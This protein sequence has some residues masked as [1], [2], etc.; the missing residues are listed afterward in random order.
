MGLPV[1]QFC[2]T[3]YSMIQQATTTVKSEKVRVTLPARP[4]REWSPEGLEQLIVSASRAETRITALRMKAIAELSRRQGRSIT[5]KTLRQ[6]C[7]Q[8]TRRAKGEVETAQRLRYLPQTSKA[9]DNGEISYRHAEIIARSAKQAPNIDERDLVDRAR[10]Q[11]ADTFAKEARRQVL[12]ASDD[13]GSSILDKQ[14]RNRTASVRL[15][16]SDGMTILFA[17]F[18]PIT[19]AQVKQVISQRVEQLWRT[20]DRNARPTT[21]QRMADALAELLLDGTERT[22]E[23]NGVGG[24]NSTLLM[25]ADYDTVTQ[26]IKNLRLGDNTPLPIG[27]LA[28]LACETKVVP[29]FFNRTGQPMW[30]GRS[31]RTASAGQRIALVA[32]D[33]GCVGC[34]ADPS[35]CQAHHIVP[36]AEG[37]PTTLENMCL[38]CSRCHHQ[39][40]DEGWGIHK[41]PRNGK[42]SLQPPKPT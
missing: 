25:I 10:H 19:G 38:L 16:S 28:R 37:G 33:R 22:A 29:A 2:I 31:K 27:A 15:D 5:E 14:R 1:S 3:L 6:E 30:L 32:R 41:D 17:R 13:D 36:W 7:G 24:R 12:Q 18:D 39:V 8:P 26:Q 4:L 35:W 21:G 34:D 11:P 40:H 42:L 23:Q 9:L 20:E